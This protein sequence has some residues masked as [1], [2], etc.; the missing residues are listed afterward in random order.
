MLAFCGKWWMV[1]ETLDPHGRGDGIH[2]CV[3]TT[4][5]QKRPDTH[6]NIKTGVRWLK[7]SNDPNTAQD[8]QLP[9][10]YLVVWNDGDLSQSKIRYKILKELIKRNKNV[11]KMVK[12][13]K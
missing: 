9:Y 10:M 12:Y 4:P 11:H 5:S 1:E 2:P 6:K 3:G 7:H 8:F 13:D